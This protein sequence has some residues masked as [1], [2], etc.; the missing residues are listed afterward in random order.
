MVKFKWRDT[1]TRIVRRQSISRQSMTVDDRAKNQDRVEEEVET[2]RDK[3]K[4]KTRDRH[5][6]TLSPT[7]GV[8]HISRSNFIYTPHFKR[9]V[10]ATKQ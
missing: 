6:H 10:S 3:V 5:I 2:G 9:D 8:C 1:G 7:S 4:V